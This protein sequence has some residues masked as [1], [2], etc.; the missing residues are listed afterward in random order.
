MKKNNKKLWFIASLISFMSL[1]LGQQLFSFASTGS[2]NQTRPSHTLVS[3]ETRE[4]TNQSTQDVRSEDTTTTD[5]NESYEETSSVENGSFLESSEQSTDESVEND[6]PQTIAQ[7]EPKGQ[8]AENDSTNSAKKNSINLAP[9][10]I[11]INNI[12][13][14]FKSLG[15]ETNLEVIQASIDAGFIVSTISP[16]NPHDGQTTY[17]G[18]H[19]PGVMSFMEANMQTDSIVTIVDGNGHPYDY[20]AI[21][22]GIVDQYGETMLTSIGM[23]VIDLFTYGS[24]Q[25][26]IAIQYCLSNSELMVMWYLVPVF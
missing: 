20:Q 26:S 2:M 1:F 7:E 11:G 14:S 15:T 6:T 19:N 5:Q 24:Q 22:H 13:K 12:F 10:S 8:L 21:D 9:N 16:F 3:N 25:E 23:N 17:F 4:S 18:G